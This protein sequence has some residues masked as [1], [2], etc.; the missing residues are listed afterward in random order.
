MEWSS[1]HR[2]QECHPFD[3]DWGGSSRY[4]WR[5]RLFWALRGLVE[6]GINGTQRII[7]R[8][9]VYLLVLHRNQGRAGISCLVR[10]QY[11]SDCFVERSELPFQLVG[12]SPI[13]GMT[14]DLLID[15][16]DQDVDEGIPLELWKCS[17]KPIEILS[18]SPAS[19]EP[20]SGQI[21]DGH[22]IEDHV[23]VLTY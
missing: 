2:S 6:R 21:F 12:Q 10:V 19:P 17:Q 20:L 16:I 18:D 5:S 23:G 7:D 15:L 11:I 8:A 4:A 1:L 3:R 22:Y 13:V 9:R 14:F